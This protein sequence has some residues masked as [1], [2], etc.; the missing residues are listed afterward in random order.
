[1][2]EAVFDVTRKDQRPLSLEQIKAI[3][4][5]GERERATAVRLFD[6][7]LD[8]HERVVPLRKVAAVGVEFFDPVTR[9]WGG[10]YIVREG[11][12]WGK[13]KRTTGMN[14]AWV[15]NEWNGAYV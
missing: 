13:V 11:G 15:A 2:A 5:L 6:N 7:P 10:P 8:P 14:A 3:A 12:Q 9:Q 4:E 1:M